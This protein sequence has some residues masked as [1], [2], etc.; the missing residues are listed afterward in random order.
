[1]L[2]VRLRLPYRAPLERCPAAAVGR[3]WVQQQQRR[4]HVSVGDVSCA[5]ERCPAVR[6]SP[7][8]QILSQPHCGCRAV[9]HV[10]QGSR[11]VT[12]GAGDPRWPLTSAGVARGRPQGSISF[13]TKKKQKPTEGKLRQICDLFQDIG[14]QRRHHTQ[15]EV[16]SSHSHAA[17]AT[18]GSQPHT[19][20]ALSGGLTIWGDVSCPGVM[21]L[22]ERVKQCR[23]PHSGLHLST[24]KN[25]WSAGGLDILGVPLEELRRHRKTKECSEGVPIPSPVV[26]QRGV[27]SGRGTQLRFSALLAPLRLVSSLPVV[28]S[29]CW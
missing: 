24:C 22:S 20:L 4:A 28:L 29:R 23:K 9:T 21:G 26:T 25:G 11:A 17:P 15:G 8:H 3:F 16:S 12:Q 5:H 1:M 2:L 13:Y 27:D 14:P 18:P 7:I 6:R 10:M 19:R